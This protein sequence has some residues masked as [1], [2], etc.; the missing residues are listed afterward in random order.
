MSDDVKPRIRVPASA[1]KG[2]II[3][4]KTLVTHPMESGQRKDSAG[5]TVAR[6][7]INRLTVTYNGKTVFDARLEPAIAANPYLAFY[8]RAEESGSLNFTW[9]DDDGSKYTAEQKLTVA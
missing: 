4:I 7:I 1:K 6:K 9:L 5:N 2:E 3:E 8:V